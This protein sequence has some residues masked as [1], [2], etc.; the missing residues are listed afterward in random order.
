M[1][2]LKRL[3]RV[4]IYMS[5][6]RELDKVSV[7]IENIFVAIQDLAKYEEADRGGMVKVLG[8]GVECKPGQLLFLMNPRYDEIGYE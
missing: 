5:S 7:W 8:P 1:Q 2:Q 3:R 4:F 6:E